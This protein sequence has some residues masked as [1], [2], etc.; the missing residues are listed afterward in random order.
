MASGLVADRVASD[1]A[2]FGVVAIDRGVCQGSIRR[3]FLL[4]V[5]LVIAVGVGVALHG[6]SFVGG[7]VATA[8]G[9]AV[10]LI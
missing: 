2:S 7:V 6:A 10:A 5:A 4:S 9:V 1:G 3:C 8:Y